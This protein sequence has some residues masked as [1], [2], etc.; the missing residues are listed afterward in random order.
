MYNLHLVI[1]PCQVHLETD[2][3]LSFDAVE[4][5]LNRGTLTALTL[6]NGHMGAMVKYEQEIESDH[7]CEACDLENNNINTDEEI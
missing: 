5:L 1:G 2:E 4:S 6:F 3:R 7:D